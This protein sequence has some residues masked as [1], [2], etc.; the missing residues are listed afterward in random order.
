TVVTASGILG[1]TVGISRLGTSAVT[2]GV[3]EVDLR[4]QACL[5]SGKSCRVPIEAMLATPRQNVL[6]IRRLGTTQPAIGALLLRFGAMF[7]G[8][9]S[10]VG[11]IRWLSTRDRI[12]AAMPLVTVGVTL[13]GVGIWH[14][15]TPAREQVTR[16]APAG[17]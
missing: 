12:L 4:I 5:L 17:E 7:G 14:L 15:T 10:A 6:D 8:A 1:P 16:L 3:E 2:V 9:A 13:S 11:S